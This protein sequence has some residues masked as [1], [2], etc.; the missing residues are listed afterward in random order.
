MDS[1][2]NRGG[3]GCHVPWVSGSALV[4]MSVDAALNTLIISDDDLR[5][6]SIPP[7]RRKALTF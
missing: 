2:M 7:A 6:P 5:S 3:G 1:R 4:V